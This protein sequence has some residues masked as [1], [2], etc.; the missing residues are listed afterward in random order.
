[1]D[2]KRKLLRKKKRTRSS[3]I[4]KYRSIASTLSN[5][6]ERLSGDKQL[7]ESQEVISPDLPQGSRSIDN[8]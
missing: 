3:L 7:P 8:F 2:R 6:K 1:M 4:R 5:S